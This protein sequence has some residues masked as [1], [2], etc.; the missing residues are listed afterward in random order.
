MTAS[1]SAHPALIALGAV[2]A[3]GVAAAVWGI[4]IERYLFTVREATA[5]ALP[6]GFRPIRVLHVSDAHMAPWQHRKQD[7]LASL[8]DLE[9]DLIVN[10]GD[11]LGHREGLDGIRR[12]FDAFAGIPGVFVHGSNDVVAPTPRNPLRYFLGPSKTKREPEML[13]TDAMNRYFT[14]DLGWTDLNNSAAR[15]TVDG[16][17]IDVFGV[18]DAHRDWDRLDVLPAAIDALGTRDA[19]TPLLGVTHAPYQRV[20][21]RFTDL[22]ADA[23]FGGHTHG[24]QVCLPGY[25]TLVANCDIP[26]KQAKGLSTWS[27]EGRT[28]PLNVSAGCGHSIYAPVRFACRPEATLLTLTARG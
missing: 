16:T 13:D 1:R 25:G 20:L 5:S 11:N 15:L 18:S 28:V 21:N 24:G 12:A 19:T 6:P 23:I 9:P 7:W 26:L 2:G 22:G 3:A 10:T 14:D 4:G 8:A 27:H 17:A